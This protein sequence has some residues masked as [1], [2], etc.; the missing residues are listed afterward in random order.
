MADVAPDVE[1]L[2]AVIAR[3]KGDETVASYVSDRVYDRVPETTDGKPKVTS[4]YIS[5]GATTSTPSDVDCIDGE[6]ISFQVDAWS[7][8]DGE[9]YSSAEVRKIGRAIKRALHE[10]EFDLSSNALASLQHERS[11]TTRAGDGVT[12]HAAVQFTAVVETP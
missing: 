12:N 1:L 3:L 2:A 10:A 9:A 11:I 7:W 4:P 8:G 6:E 5:L